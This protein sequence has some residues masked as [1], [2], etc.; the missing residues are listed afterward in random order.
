M[1]EI[2]G[3][4]APGGGFLGDANSAGT[5][6]FADLFQPGTIPA[7]PEPPA[8]AGF[9][10]GALGLAGLALAARRRAA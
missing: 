10:L 9:V 7:A 6:D 5:N 8:F 1:Q 3:V 4:S 2:F